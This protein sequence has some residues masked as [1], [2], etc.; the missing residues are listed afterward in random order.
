MAWRRGMVMCLQRRRARANVLLSG[1]EFC[2]S[3]QQIPM[4]Y[5]EVSLLV[6]N[7]RFVS[8]WRC[9]PIVVSLAAGQTD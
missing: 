3:N 6:S 1:V 4:I 9:T 8:P 7:V 5:L 2:V